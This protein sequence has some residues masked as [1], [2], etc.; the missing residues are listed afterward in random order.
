MSHILTFIVTL[1]PHLLLSVADGTSNTAY[2]GCYEADDGTGV[3]VIPIYPL[4]LDNSVIPH[5]VTIYEKC[6]SAA[7][8]NGELGRDDLINKL[9]IIIII[10]LFDMFL[11]IHLYNTTICFFLI[12][13]ISVCQDSGVNV[14]TFFL[15]LFGSVSKVQF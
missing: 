3:Y 1:F 7:V 12:V 2:I 8:E 5:P 4:G 10:L 6:E 15:Y 11:N 9:F 14:M 13:A